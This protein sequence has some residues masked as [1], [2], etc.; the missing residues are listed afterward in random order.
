MMVGLHLKAVL[1][2][3]QTHF[4]LLATP[5]RLFVAMTASEPVEKLLRKMSLWFLPDALGDC[6]AQFSDEETTKCL[7][8]SL[9]I[10]NKKNT[11]N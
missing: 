10:R 7:M 1:F 8:F 9:H 4:A 11:V 2:Y 6:I 3:A 5:T